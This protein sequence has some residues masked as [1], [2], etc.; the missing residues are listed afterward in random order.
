MPPLSSQSNWLAL[1]FDL[2][3]K[4]C[5][6][7]GGGSVAL[8][9]VAA[10]V[11]AQVDVEIVAPSIHPDIEQYPIRLT[12]RSFVDQDLEGRDLVVVATDDQPLNKHICHLA[13]SRGIWVNAA[14]KTEQ[15]T[16]L[17]PANFSQ[18]DLQVSV[19]TG[20]KAPS[21]AAYILEDI[22]RR[23][24]VAW[25]EVIALV[26][27]KRSLVREKL[28]AHDK[29]RRFW[30]QLFD[31]SFI[32]YA[33]KGQRERAGEYLEEALNR[34]AQLKATGRVYLVG[35]GPGDPEL[36]TL[37]AFDLLSCAQVVLYD[38]LVSQEILSLIPAG[39]EMICVGKQRERHLYG[40]KTI[41]QLLIDYARA[42][43][44]IVRL[45]GGDPFIFGRGGEEMIDLA[46]AKIDFQIIPGISAAN[47]CASYYGIPLTHRDWAHSCLF[48]TAHRGAGAQ[49]I[50]WGSLNKDRQTLVLY[51]GNYRLLE[52]CQSL[53]E[54]GFA[55]TMPV[56]VICAGTTRAE[57]LWL[58]DLAELLQ[59]P[60]A[61]PSPT[62]VIV[63]EVVRLCHKLNW[64][65]I[66][67]LDSSEI[68]KSDESS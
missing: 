28:G 25:S 8:K 15:G 37:R 68:S 16:V 46:E 66:Q 33:L 4:K 40:Q 56:A 52:V 62:L 3:D 57:K 26:N 44:T 19:D 22:R 41:N 6:I 5:L 49:D 55:P 11:R 47:G 27:Q 43:K 36:L 24:S 14:H 65:P 48:M 13:K 50:D 12:R 60:P 45:K 32:D 54:A 35:A 51:M 34:Q 63:G 1:S 9:R 39:V 61:F 18:G 58:G 20:G 10:L 42:G 2:K 30:R 23:Y 64:R 21:V 31:S 17:F 67:P 53:L 7:V 59:R 29:I 38:R